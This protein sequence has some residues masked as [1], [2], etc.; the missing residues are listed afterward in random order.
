M[1]MS[2][3]LTVD[4]GGNWRLYTSTLPADSDPIGTVTR[5]GYDTGALVRIAKTGKYV[6]VNAGAI[7]S[8][9]GRTIAS[10]LG[11]FG[12]PPKIADGR[13]VQVYLDPDSLDT[14]ARIGDGSMSA[15]IRRALSAVK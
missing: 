2:Q 10:L 7:R 5:D 4:P 11:L 15:G 13:R 3:I 1:K 6:Q 12:R 14:A 9:D 8:L